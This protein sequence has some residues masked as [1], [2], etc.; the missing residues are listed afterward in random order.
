MKKGKLSTRVLTLLLA[1][2]LILSFTAC[3][4]KEEEKSAEKKTD[5]SEEANSKES[6]DDKKMYGSVDVSEPAKVVYYHLGD[7]PVDLQ[8]VLDHVNEN[9][10]IPDLNT[11]LEVKYLPWSDWSTQYA[12]TL[13][14]GTQV[15]LMYTSDWAF[16]LEEASKGAFIALDKEFIKNT[17]PMTYEKQPAIS[18]EEVKVGGT[19]YAV[20]QARISHN[21]KLA[22][23]REDLRI[24]YGLDPIET[25]DDFDNYLYKVAEMGEVIPFNGNSTGHTE[26][27]DLYYLQQHNYVLMTGDFVYEYPG[28]DDSAST[29]NAFYLF[30]DPELLEFYHKMKDFADAGIIP[31]NALNNDVITA[32]SYANGQSASLVWNLAVYSNGKK[33]R[34]NNEEW[35]PGYVDDS[36][37]YLPMKY[38]N[39]CVA[40]TTVSEQPERAAAV[41]DYM[42]FHPEVS[43][44]L[45]TGLPGV[46]YEV[47]GVNYLPNADAMVNYGTDAWTWAIRPTADYFNGEVEGFYAALPDGTP[48]EM[49]RIATEEAWI[50]KYITSPKV[51]AMQFD[52]SSVKSEAAAISAIVAEYHPMLSYGLVDDVDATYA[53]FMAELQKAGIEDYKAEYIRQL[54]EYIEMSY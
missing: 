9:Y 48:D 40:I 54:Q 7:E 16:Y 5:V 2:I 31:K 42:K 36:E 39:D 25:L 34:Q 11:T 41:L 6:A 50:D 33:L 21:T 26:L 29:D 46:H 22:T 4:S 17:M 51:R 28:N 13:Q 20:P 15:D 18:W 30:E 43:F 3:N 47:D 44:M 49:A 12:L 24:K 45:R 38:S 1:A 35:I 53:E 32:D 19:M 52:K 27:T 8:M 10:L 37:F 23:Y 14:G